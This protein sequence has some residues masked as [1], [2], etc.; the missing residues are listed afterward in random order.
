MRSKIGTLL[1]YLIVISFVVVW[2]LPIFGALVTAFRTMDDLMMGSFWSI[3]SEFTL[4]NF[5]EAWT[6]GRLNVYL[7]NSFIITLPSLVATLFLSSLA[8]FAL[9]VYRFR[10]NRF[11]YLMFVA[12]MLI[13]FQVLMIPVFRLTNFLG[14]YDSY[15]GIILIHLSFQIGFCSFFL[16]NFMK[17]IPTELAEASRIDGCSEFRIFWQVFLPLA[18]PALAAVGTLQ[19]TWIFNDY[20]WGLVLLRSD[21]LKPITAGLATLQG[22]FIASWNVLVAGSL[23]ATIPTVIVFVFLQ[24]YFIEGLTMGSGK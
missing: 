5:Q 3:P 22:N 2:L 15:L 24:R 17:T 1:M 12:G 20:L 8:A 18:K 10:A 21:D 9:A 4:E 16:R 23:I 14:L 13:P 7:R 6:T 19:F 11:L